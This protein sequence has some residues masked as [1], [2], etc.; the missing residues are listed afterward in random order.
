MRRAGLGG[1]LARMEGAQCHVSNQALL[2]QIAAD[3]GVSESELLA[4]AAEMTAIC[5]ERGI[6][7]EAAMARYWA[8][9]LGIS[10]AEVDAWTAR[11]Q[12]WL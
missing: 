6:T 4:E 9:E 8:D 3:E 7:N 10:Q 1:R 12:A 11:Y 5:R 2:R